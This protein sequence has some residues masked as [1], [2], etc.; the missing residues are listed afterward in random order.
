[1]VLQDIFPQL[2]IH[3]DLLGDGPDHVKRGPVDVEDH[4]L[5]PDNVLGVSEYPERGRCI[6]VDIDICV[7]VLS[8]NSSDLQIPWTPS[9]SEQ[10]DMAGAALCSVPPKPKQK[11]HYR[12]VRGGHGQ[13][14]LHNGGREGRLSQHTAV[15]RVRR[16]DWQYC[17]L[18]ILITWPVNWGMEGNTLIV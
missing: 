5:A 2:P 16:V 8:K 3:G 15:I 9:Y 4:Q 18:S 11:Q 13:D 17:E 1:M 6:G 12:C 14:H 10:G 7:Y